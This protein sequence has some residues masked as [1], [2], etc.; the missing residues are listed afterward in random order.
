VTFRAG[1]GRLDFPPKRLIVAEIGAMIPERLQVLQKFLRKVCSLVCINSLHPSTIRIQLLLQQFLEV[2]DRMENILFL[3]KK[4]TYKRDKYMVQVFVHSI[5]QMGVMD[6]VMSG[7]IDSFFENTSIEENKKW[8]EAEGRKVINGM[9]DFVDNLEVVL[10]EAIADDCADIMRKYSGPVPGSVRNS[11]HPSEDLLG[12]LINAATSAISSEP[13]PQIPDEDHGFRKRDGSMSSL[14]DTNNFIDIDAAGGMG[15]G[16]GASQDGE[17]LKEHSPSEYKCG[18]GTLDPDSVKRS[19]DCTA[20]RTMQNGHEVVSEVASDVEAEMEAENDRIRE[21]EKE[22]KEI[23]ERCHDDEMRIQ[24]RSAVRRQVEIEVVVPCASRLRI[25]LNKA[26]A[27]T[28]AA[29]RKNI[30]KIS[31][32]P[33]SFFG[34]PVKQ[35]SESNWGVVVELMRDIRSK[36]LPHDRLEALLLTAK[37]IPIHFVRE[38]PSSIAN[39]VTLG[40]DDFLPIFIYIIARANVPDIYAMS[41]ELQALCD[42]DKRMSETG[43]YLATLEASLQHIIEANVTPESQVLFPDTRENKVESDDGSSDSDEDD[44]DDDDDDENN[45]YSANSSPDKNEILNRRR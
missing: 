3:E 24:I 14:S 10:Y 26:F 7:Y 39:N 16:M 12:T 15:M 41:E 30:L 35:I 19:D 6:K 37:E 43:Y 9:R 13:R 23:I 42:P 22:L 17:E 29:L 2:T 21:R 11:R 38:H 1:I 18:V 31:N 36:T 27:T 4:S 32:Q 44:E 40:A 5:M 34:I 28:E 33:Q 20:V 8:T 45:F 25:I